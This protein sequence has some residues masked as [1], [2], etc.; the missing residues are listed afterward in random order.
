MFHFVIQID[1]VF[2]NRN[3]IRFFKY[4][5]LIQYLILL[6]SP[7]QLVKRRCTTEM[8]EM[9]ELKTERRVI[10]FSSKTYYLG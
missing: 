6:N 5:N 1:S 8:K 2:Y 7:V 10:T 3:L 9:I 4:F